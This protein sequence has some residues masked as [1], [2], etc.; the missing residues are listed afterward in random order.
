MNVFIAKS[1]KRKQ[2]DLIG[3]VKQLEDCQYACA[4][5]QPHLTADVSYKEANKETKSG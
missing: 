2:T 4:D 1:G 5:E 3:I